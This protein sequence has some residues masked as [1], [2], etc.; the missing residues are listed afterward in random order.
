MNSELAVQE[1]HNKLEDTA[2]QLDSLDIWLQSYN[3][4]LKVDNYVIVIDNSK[5]MRHYIQEI[6]LKNN[7][8]EIVTKN[9][10]LLL[11][12]VEKLLVI[13]D[14]L[15][16]TCQKELYLSKGVITTLISPDFSTEGL[17]DVLD[18]TEAINHIFTL[19]ANMRPET[20]QM[21]SIQLCE[22]KSL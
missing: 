5:S 17:N 15:F 8:M 12:H 10:T 2:Q 6:E 18:A 9:H 4:K 1:V 11:S 22:S 3:M 19:Y 13:D 7:K 20:K 14:F 16:I 21:R